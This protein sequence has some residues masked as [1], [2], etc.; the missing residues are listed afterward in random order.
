MRE[1]VPMAAGTGSVPMAAGTGSFP[2]MKQLGIRIPIIFVYLHCWS[3]FPYLSIVGIL[4][5]P[6]FP[7]LE[8]L[9]FPVLPPLESLSVINRFFIGFFLRLSQ[10][11]NFVLK[12]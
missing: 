7:L 4:V 9:A 11:A 1:E 5:V 6:I 3:I 10:G 8:S 2:I 12:Q